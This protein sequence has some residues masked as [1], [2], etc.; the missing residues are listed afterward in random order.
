M[1]VNGSH[2]IR[3][4]KTPTRQRMVD[5]FTA[6]PGAKVWVEVVPPEGIH[7]RARLNALICVTDPPR[8]RK[9]G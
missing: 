1:E 3:L 9:K 4:T 7:P 2:F 8:K 5:R 6:L